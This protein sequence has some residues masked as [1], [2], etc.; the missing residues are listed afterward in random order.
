MSTHDKGLAAVARVRGVREQDSRTGLQLANAEQ[1]ARQDRLTELSDR[2]ASTPLHDGAPGAVISQRVALGFLGESVVAAQAEVTSGERVTA[3]AR[4]RWEQ[5]K[6]RLSAVE[7]LLQRRTARRRKAA[8]RAAAR[9]ADDLA[10]Q[11]WLRRRMEN[12]H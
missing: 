11:R 8:E 7:Q 10:A 3:A 6:T 4:G 5:D 1:A 9:D 2:L 12:D